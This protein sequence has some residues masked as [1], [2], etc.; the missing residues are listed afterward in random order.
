MDNIAFLKRLRFS[1]GGT[2][3]L[4]KRNLGRAIG[5]QE[6]EKRPLQFQVEEASRQWGEPFRAYLTLFEDPL[7]AIDSFENSY[8]G[9]YADPQDFERHDP[10]GLPGCCFIKSPRGVYAFR[11]FFN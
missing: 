1:F 2:I 5:S 4:V 10:G 8:A 11:N 6:T 3:A 9:E 7:G